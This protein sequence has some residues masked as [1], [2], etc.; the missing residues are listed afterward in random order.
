MTILFEYSIPRF[1]ERSAEP[2]VPP[3]RFAP[4]GMTKERATVLE[5]WLLNRGAFQIE[6]RGTADPSTAGRDRSASPDFLSRVEASVNCMW[7][8]LGR[9]TKVALVRA[10]K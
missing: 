1:Q 4:V 5:E 7:F 2:Q 3:L 10:V 9:T 8:S 6:V